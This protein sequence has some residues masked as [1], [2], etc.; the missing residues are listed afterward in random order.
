MAIEPSDLLVVNRDGID[1]RSEA[2][3]LIP[4]KGAIEFNAGDGLA[5]TGTNATANQTGDTEKTFSVKTGNGI[6][7]DSNGNVI[8]DPSFNLDGNITAPGDG[9]INVDAGLGLEATGTNATANQTTGTTRILSAKTAGGITIDG[10]GNIIIDPSFNLDGN[11]TPPGD[12]KIT[13][14]DSDGTKVGEFTVNQTGPTVITLP[15]VLAPNALYPSG[16][17]DVSQPAPADPKQGDIYIQHRN[18][19]ADVVADSSFA[20][21]AGQ[22][23]TDGQFVMFA[24]DDL[25]H[26]GG[27]AAPTE[28]QSDWAETDANAIEFIKNK[29]DIPA[30]VDAEAGDGAINVNAGPGLEATGLNATANQ[31]TG[32]TRVLSVKTGNGIDIDGNGNVIIDPNVNLDANVTPPNDGVLTVKDHNGN[33]VGTFTANQAGNTDVSLPKEFSGDWSDLNGKPCLYECGS[34]IP[35]LTELP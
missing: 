15:E 22:T 34:Y 29:P 3:E 19:L 32:T 20:G 11:I 2:S 17:I 5:E 24:A 26:A 18:D 28:N 10:S 35:S 31:K 4:G 9:A 6:I 30:I 21:I 23:V 12:G 16:F 25:W 8:I 13:I 1:Y 33:T 27:N 7:I 14:N